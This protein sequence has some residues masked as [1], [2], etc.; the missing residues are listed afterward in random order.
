VKGY[1]AVRRSTRMLNYG[2][3]GDMNTKQTGM[4]DATQ[5]ATSVL[6]HKVSRDRFLPPN[7][8]LSVPHNNLPHSLSL[9]PHTTDIHNNK[10]ESTVTLK[11][12]RTQNAQNV[13]IIIPYTI[14]PIRLLTRIAFKIS[15]RSLIYIRLLA[16]SRLQMICHE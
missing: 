9:F 10:I 1:Y 12:A 8:W 14:L 2:L 15:L 13:R 3:H 16:H 5:Q 4:E 6:F 7:T 11:I